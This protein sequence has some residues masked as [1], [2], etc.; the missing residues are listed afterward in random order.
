MIRIATE[1]DL[2]LIA[3]FG[4][5]FLSSVPSYNGSWTEDAVIECAR[6]IVKAPKEESIIFLYEDK[7]MLVGL[8]SPFPFGDD[9]VATELAWW[10]EPEHRKTGVGWELLKIFEMWAKKVGCRYVTMIGLD[11]DIDKF[12]K[13]AGY[14]AV[15]RTYMKE[16][17]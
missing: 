14:K 9:F 10:V 11:K 8:K 6:R 4:F 17:K 3:S 16:L 1:E 2:P 5:K 12:Y 13:K 7:G 15:E